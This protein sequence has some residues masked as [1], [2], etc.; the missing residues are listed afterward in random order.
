MSQQ[1]RPVPGGADSD[2]CTDRF[3]ELADSL[4]GLPCEEANPVAYVNNPF[5]LADAMMPVV[6]LLMVA[7]A[8]LALVHAVLT[9]RRTGSAV[10]LGVWLAA[11]VYVA[12]L[13]PPLYFP[14]VFGIDDYVPAIFVHNQFSVGFVYERMPLYILSLY[15]ALVYLSWV[16]VERLGVRRRNPGFRGALLT[17][18]CVGFTHHSIYEIFDHLGPQRLWWAWDFELPITEDRLGSVPLSSIVN[19]ALVMPTAFALLCL[20][21]LERRPRPTAPSV[22]LGAIVVGILT[23]LVSAPGQLPV[24][25]LDLVDD[26]N[27]TVVRVILVLMVVAAGLLTLREVVRSGREPRPRTDGF[28][29]WYPLAFAAAYLLTFVVLWS[30]ALPQTLGADGGLTDGGQPVGSLPYVALCFALSAAIL[31]PLVAAA[32]RPEREPAPTA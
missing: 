21:V 1:A 19:F 11:V 2:L 7:G 18:I 4:G 3:R 27:T 26:P 23:P 24:T 15:P 32:V 22:V 28:L 10:N 14:A 17:A 9:L 8:V 12:V 16:I 29:G 20:L 30:W 31:S 25:Y 6:E 13:E 5:D